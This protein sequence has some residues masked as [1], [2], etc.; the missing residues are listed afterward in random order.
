MTEKNLQATLANASE[1]YLRLLT[2]IQDKPDGEVVEYTATEKDTGVIMDYTGKNKL[3]RAII[4]SKREYSVIPNTGYKL[5]CPEITM[6]ILTFRLVGIDNKI[7]KAERS[8]KIL[9]QAFFEQL[10]KDQQNN[11]LFIGAVFGAIRS[12]AEK[13]KNIYRKELKQLAQTTPVI[14]GNV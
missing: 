9:Q 14:P 7:R 6:S 12:S 5:A 1:D 13:G 11:V 3:R 10:P 2:Y 4:R 8:Q